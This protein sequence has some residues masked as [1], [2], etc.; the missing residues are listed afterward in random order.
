MRNSGSPANVPSAVDCAV[1]NLAYEYG[2]KL[3]PE[4]GT[5]RTL[6]D[7]MQ[8]Q[9]CNQTSP[10]NFDI[11]TPPI[12]APPPTSARV[13]IVSPTGNDYLADGS[14]ARPYESIEAAVTA[15][16][17][18]PSTTILVRG[19][20]YY[21]SKPLQ[22]TAAHS[23]LTI[24]NFGG[25]HVRVSGGVPL[26]IPQGA[27]TP[28]KQRVGW[29][30]HAGINNV[31]GQVS[32][33]TKGGDGIEPLG[34]FDDAASCA[35]AVAKGTKFT[36]WTYHE[37]SFGTGFARQCFGRT[38]GAW[39]PV[40]ERHVTS[41]LLVRQNVWVA[42]LS[43]VELQRK[44]PAGFPGLRLD[45]RRAIRAKYPNGDPEASGS[46]LRGASQGMGGGDYV[47]GWIPLAANTAWVAPFRKPNATEIVVTAKDWP[48]VDW[49]MSEA[50]GS[51][52]TGEGDWGE[53]HLGLGGYCDDLDPPF[54]Y[55]CA[56]RPPRGQCWDQKTNAGRGCVQVRWS[57]V[58][59]PDVHG[60]RTCID[61]A[62]SQRRAT[63][64]LTVALPACCA[65]HAVQRML[66]TNIVNAQAS[67]AADI[68][69]GRHDLT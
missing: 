68:P 51:S 32:D 37:A 2:K 46:F 24:Q 53:Y 8:L 15:A 21:L 36:A 31:Y 17:N 14:L 22:L 26:T 65:L 50:G 64:T 69:C 60:A 13:L 63:F 27:W 67:R 28:F 40:P 10:A 6:F 11:Y 12:I 41:G 20:T 7:S 48:S 39:A 47:K 1:R 33:P 9:F 66:C 18:Q 49:P 35:A 59:W 45:G 23:G 54:G 43:G 55:W 42:S 30:I 19:G 61:A 16:V 3:L 44:L 62:P 34:L 4:R 25:E 56:M 38:D 5:F 58:W 57:T 29:E 52:W